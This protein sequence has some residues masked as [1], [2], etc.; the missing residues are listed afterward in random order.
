MLILNHFQVLT[1]YLLQKLFGPSCLALTADNTPLYLDLPSNMVY[2]LSLLYVNLSN[3]IAIGIVM[4]LFSVLHN[5]V[6]FLPHGVVRSCFQ[7]RYTPYLR[8]FSSWIVN[9]VPGKSYNVQRMEPENAWSS[10]QGSLGLRYRW[11]D[12]RWA[13]LQCLLTMDLIL[14]QLWLFSLST[15]CAFFFLFNIVIGSCFLA[16][17]ERKTVKLAVVNRDVQIFI[18]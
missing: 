10:I 1:R 13:T 7:G 16:F 4:M 2:I 9:R 3:V 14:F 18:W 15:W 12:I 5:V 17:G 8:S 6:R 11:H